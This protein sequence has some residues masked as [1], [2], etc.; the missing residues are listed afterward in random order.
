[1]SDAVEVQRLSYNKTESI[2]T[3]WSISHKTRLSHSKNNKNLSQAP[4]L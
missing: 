1:M 3:Q 4:Y 2:W